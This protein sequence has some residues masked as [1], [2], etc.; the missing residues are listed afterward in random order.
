[1]LK[2]CNII[3]SLIVAAGGLTAAGSYYF[4]KG[5]SGSETSLD[6]ADEETLDPLPSSSADY[7]IRGSNLERNF[8]G[9]LINGQEED[10][11]KE[12]CK[13]IIK[14]NWEKEEQPEM[15]L[16]VKE[17]NSKEAMEHFF[18]DNEKVRKASF[19]EKW[20]ALGLTC[21]KKSS[22]E[23]RIEIICYIPDSLKAFIRNR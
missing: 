15:W 21:E 10:M 23:E 17:K 12:E 2:G 5:N 11:S 6:S 13:R 3:W 19:G 20:D 4:R 16:R 7:I 9:K 8:C 18:P 14:G 22:S 1:M